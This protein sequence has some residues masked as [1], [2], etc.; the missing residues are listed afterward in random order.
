MAGF[1]ELFSFKS[2]MAHVYYQ[3]EQEKMCRVSRSAQ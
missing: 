1:Y 3:L 2:F